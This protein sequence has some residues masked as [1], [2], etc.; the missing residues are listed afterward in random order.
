MLATPKAI[1]PSLAKRYFKMMLPSQCESQDVAQMV[2]W[3]IHAQL[4]FYI[5]SCSS[6][7]SPPENS[8][9]AWLHAPELP[10]V[11]RDLQHAG[12]SF[13]KVAFTL[14]KFDGQNARIGK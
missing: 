11:I 3:V 8:T 13:Q 7:S 1:T 5:F 12:H 14:S 9:S 4:P 10:G 2:L 6:T